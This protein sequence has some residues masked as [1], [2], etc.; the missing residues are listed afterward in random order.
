[1]AYASTS[2]LKNFKTFLGLASPWSL[3]GCAWPRAGQTPSWTSQSCPRR[4]RGTPGPWPRRG[5]ACVHWF[6]GSA[7]CTLYTAPAP[8]YVRS[9]SAPPWTRR[10]DESRRSGGSS[11]INKCSYEHESETSRRP[12]RKSWRTDQPTDRPTDKP[13]NNQPTDTHTRTGP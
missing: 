4:T 9:P 3:E 7:G 10:S 13:T 1:M 11:E 12:F 8:R 6:R 2:R 5:C